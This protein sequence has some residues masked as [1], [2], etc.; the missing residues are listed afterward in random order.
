M[1]TADEPKET[2]IQDGT[3]GVAGVDGIVPETTPNHFQELQL[4]NKL[5]HRRLGHGGVGTQDNGGLQAESL[6]F[7]EAI[8]QRLSQHTHNST[9]HQIPHP[10]FNRSVNQPR[11]MFL[12]TQPTIRPLIH[13]PHLVDRELRRGV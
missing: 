7:D 13:N 12:L 4:F 5:H 6:P 10:T 9:I 11:N 3:S 1:H 8:N 2:T